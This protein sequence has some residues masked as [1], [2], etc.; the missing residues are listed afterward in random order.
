MFTLI[1][2]KKLKRNLTEK[3]LRACECIAA[4]P[5]LTSKQVA[6]KAGVN[7]ITVY[8]WRRHPVFIDAV[9]DRFMEIAGKELPKVLLALRREAQEGNVKAIELF[10][11][12]HKKLD[13]SLTI[14][15]KIEAPFNAFLKSE[16]LATEEAE[17]IIDDMEQSFEVLPERNVSNDNQA[18]RSKAEEKKVKK[19]INKDKPNATRKSARDRARLRLR[20]EAV[21]LEPL[22][23]G[24]PTKTQRAEWLKELESREKAI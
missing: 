10:L 23:A 14:N 15:H 21:G 16:G 9:Y 18:A 7:E 1:A 2:M 5:F 3:Q 6:E 19:I 11:R 17:L 4:D 12:H 8:R 20:A 13:N 22:G 24:R